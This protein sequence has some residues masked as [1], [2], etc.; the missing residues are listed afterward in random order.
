MYIYHLIWC[1][2]VNE[3]ELNVIFNHVLNQ[4]IRKKVTVEFVVACW[5]LI[6]VTFSY[7]DCYLYV[8]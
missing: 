5:Q 2:E 7:H 1:G 3:L 8:K 6:G 4:H